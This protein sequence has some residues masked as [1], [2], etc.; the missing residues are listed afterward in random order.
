M[1]H[2]LFAHARAMGWEEEFQRLCTGIVVEILSGSIFPR[3]RG[4]V[5]DVFC[6]TPLSLER[7]TGNADG[8]ITGWAFTNRPVPA[9]NGL[10]SLPKSILTPVE[11]ILQAGQW[12]FSPSGLPISILTGKLAA[13][14]VLKDP[15]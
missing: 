9:V 5:R 1:E 3:L 2:S 13:D 8:A 4:A 15:G 6:S 7:R 12:T 11:G 10:P 14:R